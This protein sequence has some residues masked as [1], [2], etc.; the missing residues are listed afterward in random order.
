MGAEL[1]KW[2]ICGGAAILV[3]AL[4]LGMM[5]RSIARDN[6]RYR[7]YLRNGGDPELYDEHDPY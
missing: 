5:L 7:E 1:S 6:A 3:M 2:I 4:L